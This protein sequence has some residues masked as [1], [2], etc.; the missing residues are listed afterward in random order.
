[1][2][3]YFRVSDT[4]AV[5][6]G[7]PTAE[8]LA[9]LQAGGFRAVVDLR[10]PGEPNQ[11]LA[12]D[13]EREVAAQAGLEYRHVPVPADRLDERLLAG[14]EQAMADL[15]GPVFVHCASGK[16]S[17]TLAIMHHVLAEGASG[18]QALQRIEQ[19]GSAY[20][21]AEMRAVVKEFIDRRR[22]GGG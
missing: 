15:T 18:Q 22:S 1:M 13:Q 16:R 5:G 14:F 20:G 19:E 3:D 4:L 11:V 21:S 2:R 7:Q 17:G 9:A 8:D 12:P 10:Q 6:R